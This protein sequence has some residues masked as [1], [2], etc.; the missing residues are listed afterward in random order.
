M[1]MEWVVGADADMKRHVLYRRLGE[2]GRWE[3]LAKYDADSVKRHD[4]TIIVRDNPPYSQTQRYYYYMK[5]VNASPFNS[6]S[7]AVSWK[8]HGPRVLNVPLQ[9]SGEYNTGDKATV[10]TW[11]VNAKDLP[12]GNW[13]YCIYRKGPEDK[14]FKYYMSAATSDTRYVEHT[15]ETGQTA[16]YYIDLRFEDG[17]HS[18][19]SNTVSVTATK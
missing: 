3:I 11:F 18:M 17:R 19:P 16:E 5:S 12:A 15:L 14:D 10:L 2:E 7:L 9:L 4:N 6:K 13:H 8:H 1:Y